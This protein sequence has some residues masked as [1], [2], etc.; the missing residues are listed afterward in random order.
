MRYHYNYRVHADATLRT[1]YMGIPT[2]IQSSQHFFI[3][4]SLC[5]IFATMMNCA[6]CVIDCLMRMLPNIASAGRQLPTVQEYIIVLL[7]L[8]RSKY[9]FQVT[10]NPNLLCIM[11]IYGMLFMCMRSFLTVKPI[12]LRLRSHIRHRLRLTGFSRH[13][14]NATF[15]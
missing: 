8:H 13:L 14:K 7:R 2:F 9:C 11:M 10:G 15:A 4:T 6:W 3:E 1:Y 5:E 12:P